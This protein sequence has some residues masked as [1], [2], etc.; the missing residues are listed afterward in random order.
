VDVCMCGP[1][2]L[3]EMQAALPALERGPLDEADMER[4]RRVGDYVRQHTRK[5]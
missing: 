5:F 4:M 3:N 2:N 1:K